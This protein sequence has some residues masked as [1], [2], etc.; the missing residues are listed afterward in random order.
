MDWCVIYLVD[1]V[2][3]EVFKCFVVNRV[4]IIFVFG[5]VVIGIMC[6]CEKY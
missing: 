1:W 3:F 4:G 6:I 2:G 5:K